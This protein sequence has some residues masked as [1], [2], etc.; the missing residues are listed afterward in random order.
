MKLI[1]E[2]G[3]NH[4]GSIDRANT[5]LKELCNTSVDVISFQ[6]RERSFYD[7]SHP[8]KVELPLSFYKQATDYVHSNNK[9]ISIS[10][11][12][13]EKISHFDKIGVDEWKVLSWD[14]SNDKLLGELQKTNKKIYVSTGMSSLKEIQL[15]SKR[16][17]ELEFIHTQ[18]NNKIENA[19]LKAINTIREST[20]HKVAFGLHCIEHELLYSAIAFE[21]SAIFFYV[22]D[23]TD[24]EHPDD[25]HAISISHLQDRINL[26]K[27][28]NN[29]LGNGVKNAMKNT[30]HP[31]DDD[32]CN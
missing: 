24:G 21:P 22:K 32:I 11:A 29:S 2:I 25:L 4:C 19:N 14:I 1:A 16:W 5:I 28:L 15:V 18:L 27:K 17:K 6:V 12:E 10:I 8:R 13:Y 3:L 23:E 30:M 31:D 7:N 26:I 9:L 20:G